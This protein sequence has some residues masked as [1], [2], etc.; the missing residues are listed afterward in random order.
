M[1][2]IRLWKQASLSVRASLWNLEEGGLFTRDSERQV[3]D[4]SGNGKS[5]SMG[6]LSGEP[7]GGGGSLLGTLKDT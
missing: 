2:K 3:K 4:A 1:C 5:L 6:A 7:V